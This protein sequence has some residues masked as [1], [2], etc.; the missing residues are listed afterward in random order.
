MVILVDGEDAGGI[1]HLL[2]SVYYLA[3]VPR[4]R[5]QRRVLVVI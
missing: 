5:A 3:Q 4:P 2:Q 1:E